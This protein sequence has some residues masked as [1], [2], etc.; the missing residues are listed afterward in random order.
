VA[1]TAGDP[2]AESRFE[3]VPGWEIVRVGLQD[4]EN[5]RETIPALLTASASQRLRRLGLHVPAIA[6]TD[7]PARLFSLIQA[8]V[9]PDRAHSRYNA[10][11][12]RLVS[13]LRTADRAPTA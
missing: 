13:F 11:R 3:G 12:R 9:G 6:V 4:L 8:D 5:G 1:S 7:I 10:L 2:A